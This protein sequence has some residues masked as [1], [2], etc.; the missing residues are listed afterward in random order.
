MDQVRQNTCGINISGILI[1]N[2]RF[3]DDIDLIDEDVSSLQRQIELT[4]TAAEKAGLILNINKTK[5]MVFGDRNIDNSIQVAGNTIENVEKF[6]YLGS[7]L[8]WDNNCS[9]EIKRRIGKATGAMASLRHI[10]NSKKL[11]LENKLRILTTC[12]FSVLLYASETWTLKE[13]D[14][15]KLLAF[16]MKCYRRVLKI[17]WQ[18]MVRNEDIRKKISKEETIIDTIKKRKLRLF[19]HICRMDDGRLIKH[20]I[21]GKMDGKSR[22]GRPCREW[23]DDITEWCQRSGH[24]LFHLAQDRRAWKNLI[25]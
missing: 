25:P 15:K 16:E 2:L 24:D 21:F 9:E 12:V 13:A 5:T 22:R 23:L 4:K 3:A 11:K 1:N 10:W 18:D 8:T 17:N 7:L 19:G 6:E 20:L 14:R